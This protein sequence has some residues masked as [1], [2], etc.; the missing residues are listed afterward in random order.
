MLS[1]ISTLSEKK[2]HIN[3]GEKAMD[4]EKKK[5]KNFST[6]DLRSTLYFS[7]SNATFPRPDLSRTSISC[8]HR[9]L[10]SIAKNGGL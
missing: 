7:Q 2:S 10:A 3:R 9:A 8:L 4:R 5:K 1:I 6:L